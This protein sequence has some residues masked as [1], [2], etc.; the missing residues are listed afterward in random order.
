ML[1]ILSGVWSKELDVL[2]STSKNQSEQIA[3]RREVISDLYSVLG[4]NE[5]HPRKSLLRRVTQETGVSGFRFAV[6]EN[7]HQRVI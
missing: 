3:H 2:A 1:E 5:R 4:L 6:S 7:E